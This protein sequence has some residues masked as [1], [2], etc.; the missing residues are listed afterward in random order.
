MY[1]RVERVT[2]A[3]LQT[4][5]KEFDNLHMRKGELIDAFAMRVTLTLSKMR[6]LGERVEDS[7]V[8]D[9]V[10]RVLTPKFLP[11]VCTLQNLE[12]LD[13]MSVEEMFGRLKAFEERHMVSEE[14]GE[15]L[16]LTRP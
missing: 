15:H 8:V 5:K 6:T 3:K 13:V 4:V 7:C 2:R 1:V 14:E 9:K 16:L 10:L 11:I 12:D